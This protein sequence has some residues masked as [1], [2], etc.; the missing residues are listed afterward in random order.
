MVFSSIVFLFFFLPVTLGTYFAAP[1]SWRN[2]VLLVASLVFYTWGG[3]A[4][5]LLLLVTIAI[6]YGAGRLVGWAVENGDVRWRNRGVA[7][8]VIACLG[9][10][11]YFKYANFAVEQVNQV[12]DQFGI[13]PVAWTSVA[14]P[15]GISFYTFQAMSYTIDVA[16][17]RVACVRH[18]VDFAM[19]VALFPQLIAGPI[20]RFHEIADELVSRSTNL[21]RFSAG[22]MRFVYGLAKKVMIADTLAP[23]ADI[24]FS[25]PDELS[26]AGAW[27]GLIAYTFQIYFDFSGYSDMAIGMGQMLGFHFPENFRRP[28][29]ALSITD[30]WRRWHVT[31]SNWFRDY[32]Y[33]PLG[34]NRGSSRRTSANLIAVFLATGIWHGANWTFV[35]WG[36]VHGAFMLWERRAGTAFVEGARHEAWSRARTF[37]IVMLAWVLF[38]SESLS[39]AGDY[40]FAL[41]GENRGLVDLDGVVRATDLRELVVLGVA[42]STLL[43]PRTFFG[44]RLVAEARGWRPGAAR[45]ALFAIAFPITILL[46]VSG[47]FSPFLY[48][49]F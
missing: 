3:G 37:L 17:G 5:V 19:Y 44:G 33:V 10:L 27:L 30:F 23:L 45:V 34:G 15:I 6:N 47:T 9:L 38:R 18:P 39:S 13:G 20:V 49:Q 48:F 40:F 4:F 16:R 12:S 26:A 1:R 2:A 28:Y 35:V 24:A 32:L 42:G 25:A 21:D 31:L 29:S 7:L 43:L 41:I 36:L 11:T 46:I 22:A 14:L 8:S